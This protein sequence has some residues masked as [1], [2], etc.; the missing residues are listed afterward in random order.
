MEKTVQITV[1]V[2]QSNYDSLQRLSAKLGRPLAEIV[3]GFIKDGIDVR[4]SKEDI[5]F[6]RKQLREELELVLKPQIGRLAKMMMRV[7]MMTISFCYFTSKLIYMFVPFEE[8]GISYEDLL[9]ECKHNAAAYLN[10]RDA[11]L[12]AAMKDFDEETAM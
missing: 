6:I 12:D 1:K 5:D 11:G 3:R 10:I 2:S 8:R 4:R 9:T 7:G